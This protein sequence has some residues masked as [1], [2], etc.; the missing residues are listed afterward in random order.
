MP[1][2]RRGVTRPISSVSSFEGEQTRHSLLTNYY[3]QNTQQQFSQPGQAS[4]PALPV[5]GRPSLELETKKRIHHPPKRV[6]TI[7][8][9]QREPQYWDQH[10]TVSASPLAWPGSLLTTDS[11]SPLPVFDHFGITLVIVK[12]PNQS[13]SLYTGRSLEQQTSKST[14]YLFDE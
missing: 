2:E 11:N 7:T 3:K 13:V 1:G 8:I 6:G 14:Q 10:Q 9:R 12:T 5:A 4:L